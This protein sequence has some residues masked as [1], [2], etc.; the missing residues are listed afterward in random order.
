MGNLFA[1]AQSPVSVSRIIGDLH[2]QMYWCACSSRRARFQRPARASVKA[3][4]LTL[5]VCPTML[6]NPSIWIPLLSTC[7]SSTSCTSAFPNSF[8]NVCTSLGVWSRC[9]RGENQLKPSHAHRQ[10]R[11]NPSI[12]LASFFT[13]SRQR[14]CHIGERKRDH[15]DDLATSRH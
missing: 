5:D 15:L 8:A 12:L 3:E 9:Q 6:K 10:D 1:T 7:T 11:Q 2:A 4:P 14:E 13:L